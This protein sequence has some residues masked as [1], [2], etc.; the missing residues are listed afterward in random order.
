MTLNE[1]Q[2]TKKIDVIVYILITEVVM[3]NLICMSIHWFLRCGWHAQYTDKKLN[4]ETNS[5][6]KAPQLSAFVV[7]TKIY[8]VPTNVLNWDCLCR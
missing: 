4:G 3:S 5:R 2:G 7:I 8:R 6:T 1:G